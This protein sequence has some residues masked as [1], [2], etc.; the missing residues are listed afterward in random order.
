MNYELFFADLAK[1][2]VDMILSNIINIDSKKVSKKKF[3]FDLFTFVYHNFFK[4]WFRQT[5]L[6][7]M[8]NMGSKKV[9]FLFWIIKVSNNMY[10]NL[11]LSLF[12]VIFLWGWKHLWEICGFHGTAWVLRAVG[13]SGNPGGRGIRG[14]HNLPPDWKRVNVSAKIWAF[15]PPRFRRPWNFCTVYH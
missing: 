12:I 3:Y 9:Q 14:G 15:C 6:G 7:N 11:L 2:T 8:I 4:G 1:M 5:S 13:T 10:F